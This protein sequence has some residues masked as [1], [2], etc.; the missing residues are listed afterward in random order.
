M[1][2]N[3]ALFALCLAAVLPGC[4]SLD[5]YSFETFVKPPAGDRRID[6]AHWPERSDARALL[7][8]DYQARLLEGRGT[9]SRVTRE[10]SDSSLAVGGALAG[11]QETLGIAASSIA[12]MGVGM[13]IVRELQGVV[14]ARGRSE[15]FVDAAYLIRQAQSEYR[16]FNPNPPADRLTENG[17]ILVSR[18]D[19]AV[20][21]ALKSLNGRL[22]GL[23]DLQ[24]ATQPMTKAGADRDGSGT[25][26]T[27]FTAA[28]D[29]PGQT[30]AAQQEKLNERIQAGAKLEGARVKKV[31][32]E[33]FAAI[34]KR[35]KQLEDQ[36]PSDITFTELVTQINKKAGNDPTKSKAAFTALLG[37]P[38]VKQAGL[39]ATLDPDPN[40][41][42]QFFQEQANDAQKKALIAAATQ[43]LKNM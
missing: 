18:V 1:K 37:D 8:A 28:G 32:D 33:Q 29:K 22:P 30:T 27:M 26:Q 13:V 19:A 21:A 40:K 39:P 41:I 10:L 3:R 31:S 4:A 20:H 12:S 5:K 24:Q 34:T 23:L 2:P 17:A 36:Q 7:Y 38:G 35:M 42:N 14:N 6:A 43:Q 16:Q 15:A 25:P 9:G 11:A